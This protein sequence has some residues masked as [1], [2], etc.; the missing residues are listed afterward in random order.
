M[1]LDNH[2]KKN[3]PKPKANASSKSST[4]SLHFSLFLKKR[5][6]QLLDIF[7]KSIRM[8]PHSVAIIDPD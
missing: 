2:K 6:L 5:Y 1:V 8:G 7:I 4:S 3:D